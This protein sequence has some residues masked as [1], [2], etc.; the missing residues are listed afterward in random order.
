L[1]PDRRDLPRWLLRS[2]LKIRN[3]P[4]QQRFRLRQPIRL[5]ADLPAGLPGRRIAPNC[6]TH[7]LPAMN[8]TRWYSVNRLP[9]M[10]LTRCYCSA[11]HLPTMNLTRC[12]CSA[13]HLPTMSL[14]RCYCSA[15]RLPTMSLT[16]CY[17]S[18][19][20]TTGCPSY[21]KRS[22]LLLRSRRLLFWLGA[23]SMIPVNLDERIAIGRYP[24]ISPTRVSLFFGQ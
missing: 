24:I 11:N 15:N 3:C 7:H 4:Y 23:S 17:C 16:R 21:C 5:I 1:H 8:L 22:Q 12:C 9:V 19:N 6:P 2:R 14:T 10:S 20:Q 18:A 13:N